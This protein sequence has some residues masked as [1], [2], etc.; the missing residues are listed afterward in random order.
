MSISLPFCCLETAGSTANQ[1]KPYRYLG[2]LHGPIVVGRHT[3]LSVPLYKV[4][5]SLTGNRGIAATLQAAAFN[6]NGLMVCR[7]FLAM[8]EAGF[9]P[10]VPFLLSFFYRRHELGFRCGI[11]L[12]AAPLATTFAGRST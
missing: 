9:S 3:M 10:G 8:A 5:R 4:D 11:F 7:W 1:T 6:W 2:I 12:S